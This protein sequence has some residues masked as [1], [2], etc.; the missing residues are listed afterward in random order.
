MKSGSLLGSFKSCLRDVLCNES[1]PDPFHLRLQP[2]LPSFVPESPYSAILAFFFLKVQIPSD[3]KCI[4]P[5]QFVSVLGL[6]PVVYF[7]H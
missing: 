1:Y 7:L 5:I 4:S 3:I 6:L 2:I